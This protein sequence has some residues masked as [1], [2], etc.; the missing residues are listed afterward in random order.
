[1][2]WR[3][4]EMNQ[5]DADAVDRLGSK[6]LIG[7]GYLGYRGTLE[8]HTH[9]QK[10]ATTLSGLYDQVGE[11][12]REP[13]NVPNGC[14][15]QVF[16][17]GVP[18][19][20]QRSVVE[21]HWQALD[22]HQGV[23]ERY[24]RFVPADGNRITVHSKRFASLEFL[25]LVCMQYVVEVEQD[26][27]LAIRTGIDGDVWDLNGTHLRDFEGSRRGDAIALDAA[28]HENRIPIAV[29][30]RTLCSGATE[31]DLQDDRRI[32]RE[33]RVPVRA[34]HPL[35]ITKFVAIH[36]GLDSEQPAE[37]ADRLCGDAARIGFD[38]LLANHAERWKERWEACDVRIKGDDEAERALRFSMFQLLAVAPT[39]SGQVSI[40]A[41]GLSGQVYK[42]AIFWD[43]EIFM[44]P[45]FAH[46]FPSIARNLLMYRH[47]TLGGARRKAREYGCRGAFY[48]WESQDSGDDVCTLFNITDVFT[49]RPMRTYFR[50]KQV[51]ITADVVYAIWDYF[52]ITNDDTIFTEG[53][54]EV[55]FECA[56][57]LLSRLYYS[58]E[59][60]RFELLDVTG[61]DEYH[62][63]VHNN[64]FTNRMAAH[65]FETCLRV[66]DHL[67]AHAPAQLR[68]L[69]D[70]LDFRRDLVAIREA[71][72]RIHVPEADARTGVVPQFDGYFSLEDVFLDDLL[73]RKLHPNEYLGGGNGLA[74]T[75]Q[76]IKQA[77]VI[78]MM[79]LFSQ[80]YSGATKLVN[81]DYYEPRT[82]HGSSLSA[83]AYALVAAQI[84]KIDRA[85]EYFMKAACIDL[86]GE[87]KQYV[88]TLYIGGTH[89]AA[90]GGAWMAAILGL[91]GIR[92]SGDRL[93]AKP[94]LPAHWKEV[95]VRLTFRGRRAVVRLTQERAAVEMLQRQEESDDCRDAG[96]GL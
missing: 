55:V 48:A 50:D 6:F 34:Q 67:Q 19:H 83:C 10:V 70:K 91:C 62:E 17:Q 2:N 73:A 25:H 38:V 51:H 75:T 61:P 85:Y 96:S 13:V 79:H 77:D 59:K 72:A 41:R 88:G 22:M 45:F 64:A 24:T 95:T 49:K 52:S 44:L 28:T 66:H 37:D 57:F 12:W 53:C 68:S 32:F 8:E 1:M 14:H 27:T 42:G 81:W 86:S 15:L 90:N 47:H 40:P 16:Y 5:L 31:S 43:T 80:E 82:E 30:E 21:S 11:R 4:L 69:E 60:T 54:A 3:I 18:L 58:V 33:L 74:S 78:L 36:T 76:I 29:C 39:H 93:V 65:T 84:E 26:C 9:D 87:P 71:L 7:N 35:T 46:T 63:R 56:R 94:R 23:H 89:P 92:C 20:A